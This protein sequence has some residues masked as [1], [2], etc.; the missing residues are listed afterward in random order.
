MTL[1]ADQLDRVR[2]YYGRFKQINDGIEMTE[3]SEN[4]VDDVYAFFQN[5]HHLKDWLKNDSEFT[6]Y[7]NRQIE[8]HVTNT[9]AL[10]VCAD[11]CNGRKH[12]CLNKGPRSGG[13]PNMGKKGN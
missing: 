12:L 9:P 2:R 7:T 3:P 4:Y 5:C 1:Y 8:D 6:N 13:T 11:L 10:A